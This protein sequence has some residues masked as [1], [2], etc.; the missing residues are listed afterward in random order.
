MISIAKKAWATAKGFAQKY[1]LL[2]YKR[3]IADKET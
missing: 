3:Q 1:N 2:L